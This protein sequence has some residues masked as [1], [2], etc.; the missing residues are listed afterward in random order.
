M[1]EMMPDVYSGEICSICSVF[2]HMGGIVLFLT[3]CS[4]MG[5]GVVGLS[6]LSRVSGDH[7]MASV[8]SDT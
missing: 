5:S 4:G 3:W 1:W 6:F 2:I 8:T 7:V